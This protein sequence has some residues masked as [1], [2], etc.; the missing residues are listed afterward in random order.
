MNIL[1]LSALD[2][3]AL[4]WFW[5][6]WIGYTYFSEWNARRRPS[7]LGTMDEYRHRWMRRML[8][9]DNRIVDSSIL[10]NLL[11][12]SNFFASTTIL[13]LGGLFA[14][15]TSVGKAADVVSNLP[16]SQMQT[17]HMLEIK[18]LLE[19]IIFVYAFFKFTWSMRQFNFVSIMV[20]AAPAQNKVEEFDAFVERISNV[21]SLAGE[22]NNRG[23]RAYYFGLTALAWFI[24]PIALMTASA[25]VV[26]IL[27]H[28]EFKSR[29]L[30]AMR[31]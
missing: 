7:L 23:L 15:L 14:A 8:E 19:T 13:I 16:Y 4:V 1:Q 29:T 10:R 2:Q 27:Y 11:S 25:I 22:N 9:R 3:I 31:D 20:G 17:E 5:A 6:C 28:R 30:K 24:H 21:A 26:G 18:L 12:G